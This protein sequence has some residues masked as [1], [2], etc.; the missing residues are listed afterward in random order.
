MDI[1]EG[2]R[3]CEGEGRKGANAETE[4]GKEKSEEEKLKLMN[5]VRGS[6][7]V[8]TNTPLIAIERRTKAISRPLPM[9]DTREPQT[10]LI[11]NIPIFV[12]L[13]MVLLTHTTS[14]KRTLIRAPARSAPIVGLKSFYSVP[15]T[16]AGFKTLPREGKGRRAAGSK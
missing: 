12:W 13:T 8:P 2:W 1:L 7:Q 3:Y 10:E 9:R 4:R 15:V 16:A 14:A 5:R 6:I 11:G